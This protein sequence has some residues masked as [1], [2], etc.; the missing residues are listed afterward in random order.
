MGIGAE[1]VDLTA[2][3]GSGKLWSMIFQIL[4]QELKEAVDERFA[5]WPKL[6]DDPSLAKAKQ[7][8]TAA[9]MA[10]HFAN[11]QPGTRHDHHLRLIQH[12]LRAHADAASE[13]HAAGNTELSGRHEREAE[14]HRQE[15]AILKEKQRQTGEKKLRMA[16]RNRQ[17]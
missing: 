16:G 6:S 17:P 2:L 7:A 4:V 8:T 1:V 14:R 9:R 3:A 12:A 13:H 11:A 5:P 15:L 10:S